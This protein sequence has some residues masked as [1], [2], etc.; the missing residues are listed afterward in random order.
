MPP[1]V[2][3][4]RE[5]IIKTC[6]EIVRTSGTDGINARNIAGVLGCSTQPIFSNFSSMEELEEA[7]ILAAYQIYLDFINEE[8]NSEKYPKYKAFGMAYIRFAEEEKELFRLLFMRDRGGAP[9]VSTPDF[10]ASVD[11]IMRANGISRPRAERM[12]F[13]MWA[14]VHGIATM[15]AT[16]FVPLGR[17]EIS[18][19]LTDVYQ[20]LRVRHAGEE[21]R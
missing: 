18:E 20:G 9:R 14:C 5:E 7:T 2:K 11:M 1:K 10:E 16:S 17:E 19:M 12:H 8:V 21:T 13:E 15:L 4:S 6:L 3:V